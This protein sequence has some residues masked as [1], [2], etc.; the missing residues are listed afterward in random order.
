MAKLV[1]TRGPAAHWY[2]AEGQPMHEVSKAKG[3]GM[4]NT[5]LRDARKLNL[6]PSVTTI[7]RVINKPALMRWRMRQAI[8]STLSN[9]QEENESFDYWMKRV[10]AG[11]EEETDQAA[12][13][14]TQVHHALEQAAAG[15]HYNP[16]LAV[17]VTPALNW[18]ADN[19]AKM[20]L[21]E[22]VIVDCEDGYA[23]TIDVLFKKG[24][25]VGIADYKTRKTVEGEKV[26][27]YDG[28]AMQLAAYA[29]AFYGIDRL[30]DLLAINIYIST[31]E[32]GRIEVYEHENLREEYE[33][34][35]AAC[36]LWRHMQGYDPRSS[37]QA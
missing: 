27:P 29:K 14:G 20:K 15:E 33:A 19:G 7:L 4:R 1:N 28:Q 12:D 31:T 30:D 6:Y 17:Y 13:I 35:K 2:T 25:R 16:D 11:A 9:P 26:K 36:H 23:G 32:P 21:L 8:M 24:K 5:T 10:L 3:D 18:F 37:A 34:F 22:H